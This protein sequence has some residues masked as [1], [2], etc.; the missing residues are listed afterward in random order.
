MGNLPNR[1]EQI[2]FLDFELAS[3]PDTETDE[4]RELF[5]NLEASVTLLFDLSMLLR[6]YRPRGRVRPLSV[7]FQLE[8]A[9]PDITNVGDKFPKA[10]DKPWLLQR[11]GN[12]VTLRRLRI[13]YRQEHHNSLSQEPTDADGEEDTATSKATTFIESE[14]PPEAS[15][16]SSAFSAATSLLSC[17]NSEHGGGHIPELTRLTYKGIK[18]EYNKSFECPYCCTIQKVADEWEWKY[19]PPHLPLKGKKCRNRD[20]CVQH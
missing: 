7:D 13:Q 16:A 10:K 6:R 9:S 4:L 11:L 19:D 2:A 5:L 3:E 12:A 8:T 18:L 1:N 20:P 14:S 15:Y 17:Y